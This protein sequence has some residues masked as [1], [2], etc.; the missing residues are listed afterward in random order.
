MTSNVWQKMS[1]GDLQGVMQALDS[2]DPAVR[3][4]AIL[5]LQTMSARMAIPKLR[6]LYKRELNPDLR[7][8]I[9]RALTRLVTSELP[10]LPDFDALL[11]QAYGEDLAEAELAIYALGELADRRAI[12]PLVIMFR[13]GT[14]P[15][16]LRLA[17]AESLLA[18]A[19]PPASA[20]LLGALR[21]AD[22][23]VRRNGAAVLGQLKAD[24]AVAPLASLLHD[25]PSPLVQKTAAAALKNI[26]TPEALE[27][28]QSYR[29]ADV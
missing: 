16:R 27:A 3:S 8:L 2:P 7:Q 20:A 18:L 10:P 23:Q 24:W 29:E 15:A 19:A 6:V 28:L 1:H 11:A 13:D 21:K 5:A 12:E 17:C 26:A 4:R 14:R 25:D 22:P 9:Q